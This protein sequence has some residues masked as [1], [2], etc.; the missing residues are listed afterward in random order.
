MDY[1]LEEHSCILSHG[2]RASV[3]YLHEHPEEAEAWGVLTEDW[4]SSS[5]PLVGA[6]A[7]T[8]DASSPAA[9]MVVIGCLLEFL[10]LTFDLSESK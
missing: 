8:N 10:K 5:F 2:G 3:S 6:I 1:N 4:C 7:V 9:E